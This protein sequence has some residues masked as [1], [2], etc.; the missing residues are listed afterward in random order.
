[1]REE[2]ILGSASEMGLEMPGRRM[3]AV[4]GGG[5]VGGNRYLWFS[6]CI[7]GWWNGVGR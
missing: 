2:M 4:N 3:A 6:G 1:M 5:L 7:A